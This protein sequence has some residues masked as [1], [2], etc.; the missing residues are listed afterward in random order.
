MRFFG[1]IRL[2]IREIVNKIT[3]LIPYFSFLHEQQNPSQR[4]SFMTWYW[5]KVIGYN[6]SSYWPVSHRSIVVCPENILVGK[7]SFPGLMPG[8]Y[9]QGLGK[10][11]VGDFS[12]F[13]ANVGVISANHIL[14]DIGK[15]ELNTVRIGSYCWIG[16]NA[17]ILPGVIL[18]DFTIVA[19]GSVVTK[20]FPEGYC[21]IGGN[22]ARIIKHLI[23][24][25]CNRFTVGNCNYR[26]YIPEERFEQYRKKY[27]NV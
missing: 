17:I 9:I 22:P 20:P 27:L 13:A 2:I 10:I 19:A 6:A 1:I 16:M 12:I 5:Q 3:M 26:G 18:G 24:E 23:K 15:H 4:I 21:V 14:T 8:N 25:E 11:Y 7:G